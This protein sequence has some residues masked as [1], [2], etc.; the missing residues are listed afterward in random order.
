MFDFSGCRIRPGH[1]ELSL[2][3]GG[4][5]E[6]D[7]VHL[8]SEIVSESP[9]WNDSCCRDVLRPSC[10]ACLDRVSFSTPSLVFGLQLM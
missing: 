1:S 6:S 9:F 5:L 7:A 10:S 2:S 8:L 4:G 3:A